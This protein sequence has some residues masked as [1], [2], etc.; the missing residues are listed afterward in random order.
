MGVIERATALLRRQKVERIER[1]VRAMQQLVASERGEKFSTPE[2]VLA[3]ELWVRDI[4]FDHHRTV[5]TSRAG[6]PYELDIFCPIDAQRVKVET[7][8]GQFYE[9]WNT[10]GVAV[11]CDGELWHGYA[12]AKARDKRRDYRLAEVGIL[13]LR[14]AARGIEKNVRTCGS[15]VANVVAQLKRS[16][17]MVRDE[18]LLR[19]VAYATHS[20]RC[21]VMIE[22]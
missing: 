22:T 10:A 7:L 2:L 1:Y 17:W 8:R 14:L 20:G 5:H 6:R 4:P 9:R 12:R 21:D 3:A 11:E 15:L 19:K 13:T 16:P 18:H